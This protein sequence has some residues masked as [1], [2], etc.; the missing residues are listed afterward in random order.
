M[1]L[2]ARMR[3]SGPSLYEFLAWASAGLSAIG[4]VC[5]AEGQSFNFVLP[6]FALYCEYCGVDAH[7]LCC[8]SL[9]SIPRMRL[10]RPLAALWT[11]NPR[12]I[13]FVQIFLVFTLILDI[14]Y[15]SVYAPL[16]AP[17]AIGFVATNMFAKAG[18]LFFGHAIFREMGCTYSLSTPST[19]TKAGQVDGA[20]G[21]LGSHVASSGLTASG[22]LAIGVSPSAPSSSDHFYQAPPDVSS[23]QS[24]KSQGMCSRASPTAVA[25]MLRVFSPNQRRRECSVQRWGHFGCTG[26]LPV[27]P[28]LAPQI[29]AAYTH[30]R[31]SDLNFNFKSK[32]M[33]RAH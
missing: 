26:R 28:R 13:M 19:E 18:L 7:E 25:S 15:C 11:R 10:P 2:S 27:L 9:S 8:T 33:P 6:L 20:P 12:G 1:D 23:Y 17:A 29:P 22:S 14:V 16:R 4:D 21:L 31:Q 3:T 24:P 30:V 32:L 5:G